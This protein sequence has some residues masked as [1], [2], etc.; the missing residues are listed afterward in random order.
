MYAA[1]HRLS[2]VGGCPLVWGVLAVVLLLPSVRWGCSS[3]HLF[4]CIS[5]GARC[6]ATRVP[7]V[8][9]LFLLEEGASRGPGTADSIALGS[10]VGAFTSLVLPSRLHF[11]HFLFPCCWLLS[12]SLVFDVPRRWYPAQYMSLCAYPGCAGNM[13]R[14]STMHRTWWAR[15]W[16]R[17]PWWHED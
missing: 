4:G 3:G 12:T 14:S 11:L 9:H 17:W 15:W 2:R 1:G 7:V 13:R 16:A 6:R 5:L 10:A 8:G